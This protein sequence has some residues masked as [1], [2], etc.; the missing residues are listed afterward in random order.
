M[1]HRKPAKAAAGGTLDPPHRRRAPQHLSTAL[2]VWACHRPV[3]LRA[4]GRRPPRPS[5]IPCR[6]GTRV[7]VALM[8]VKT[9]DSHKT[10]GSYSQARASVN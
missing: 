4:P 3:W 1:G 7:Q 5:V 10:H 2:W 8:V 9:W 6:L